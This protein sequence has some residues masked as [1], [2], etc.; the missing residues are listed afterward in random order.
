MQD[1]GTMYDTATAV[2]RAAVRTRSLR[3]ATPLLCR[4]SQP[5]VCTRASSCASRGWFS[6]VITSSSPAT[7][8]TRPCR[9][10]HKLDKLCVRC[11]L[12]GLHLTFR[13]APAS[14][15]AAS[16]FPKMVSFCASRHACACASDRQ[17]QR[18]VERRYSSRGRQHVTTTVGVIADALLL[19]EGAAVEGDRGD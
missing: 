14:P 9:R 7:A 3:S 13:A 5:S 1:V 10:E 4:R 11:L 15:R 18:K 12:W 16:Q 19:G 2:A 17:R 8:R 6:R